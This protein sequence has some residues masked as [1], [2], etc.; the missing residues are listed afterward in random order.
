MI[1]EIFCDKFKK[2]HV[3]FKDGLNVVLGD[4]SGANSIGK[5][6]MLLAIDYMLGGDHYQ[7][8][9]DIIKHV[10]HHTV[11]RALSLTEINIILHGKQKKAILF[12]KVVLIT[13][14]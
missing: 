3:S 2:Q 14:F 1:T 5:S 9:S 12:S 8:K 7:T 4:D 11:L 10:G 13:N 6:T